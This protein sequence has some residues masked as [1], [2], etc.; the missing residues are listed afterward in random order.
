MK[1]VEGSNAA[2]WE[3]LETC[4][5]YPLVAN[6]DA[7]YVNNLVIPDRP[8]PYSKAPVSNPPNPIFLPLASLSLSSFL[9]LSTPSMTLL[10][11]IS[12]AK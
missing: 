9:L 2:R 4:R 6:Q 3:S 10:F 7:R 1:T 11:S 8:Q 5:N 12:L